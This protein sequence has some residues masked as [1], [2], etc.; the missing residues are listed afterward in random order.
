MPQHERE[1][2][3]EDDQGH[4]SGAS[5]AERR[6]E[7]ALEEEAEARAGPDR[8]D[9]R[10][11]EREVGTSRGPLSQKVTSAPKVTS[12]PWAKFVRPVTP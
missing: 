12:S 4:V 7:T 9:R 2:D 1:P 3:R 8:E 5:A 11:H 6:E 10:G